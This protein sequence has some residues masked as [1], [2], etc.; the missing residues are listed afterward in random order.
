MRYLPAQKLQFGRLLAV[1]LPIG[2][3]RGK[4]K[5]TP[6]AHAKA[7]SLKLSGASP[8]VAHQGHL[9]SCVFQYKCALV[10]TKRQLHIQ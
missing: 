10:T 3:F 5:A 2:Q 7:L 1:G 6:T 8:I 4:F 9:S